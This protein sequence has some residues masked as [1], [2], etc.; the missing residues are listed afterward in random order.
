MLSLHC[1]DGWLPVYISIQKIFSKH[2]NKCQGAQL[3]I[4]NRRQTEQP[5]KKMISLSSQQK[6]WKCSQS[7]IAISATIPSPISQHYHF[8]LLNIN[9]KAKIELCLNFLHKK[10]LP[11]RPHYWKCKSELECQ[12]RNV[13]GASWQFVQLSLLPRFNLFQEREMLCSLILLKNEEEMENWNSAKETF[14]N[15]VVN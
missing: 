15:D 3:G 14:K 4:T 10:T 8:H 1:A 7:D 12:M 11:W 6:Y 5:S 9:N 13:Y 2:C